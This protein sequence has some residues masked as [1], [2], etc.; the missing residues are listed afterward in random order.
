MQYC[1]V[2]RIV[3]EAY[4]PHASFSAQVAF[5]L[6]DRGRCY[7]YPLFTWVCPGVQNQK[8]TSSQ[9]HSLYC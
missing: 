8:K 9:I 1:I 7:E 6:T 4:D 2:Y 3:H 5:G